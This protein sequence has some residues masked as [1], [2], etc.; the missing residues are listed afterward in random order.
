MQRIMAGIAIRLRGAFGAALV[1][2]MPSMIRFVFRRRGA[3][4][5]AIAGV[6]L[7]KR[8]LAGLVA[9]VRA[10]FGAAVIGAI[11]VIPAGPAAA[12]V[13]ATRTIFASIINPPSIAVR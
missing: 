9:R 13:T 8:L 5:A 6:M 2:A 4:G 3:L 7:G 12:A 11:L 1:R 10:A